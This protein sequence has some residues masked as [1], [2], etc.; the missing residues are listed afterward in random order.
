M[1]RFN[2]VI[3]YSSKVCYRKLNYV[4][5]NPKKRGLCEHASD[6][7]YC[8]AGFYAGHP[9]TKIELLHLSELL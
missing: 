6:Y 4:N 5:N 2:D 7:E 8:S 9:E 1:D 3:L